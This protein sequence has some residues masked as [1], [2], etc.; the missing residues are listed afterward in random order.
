MNQSIRETFRRDSRE[1]VN[2]FFRIQESLAGAPGLQEGLA[3]KLGPTPHHRPHLRRVPWG[4][5]AMPDTE[6]IRL[7]PFD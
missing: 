3:G 4:K 1:F 6:S 5:S 7:Q 2:F